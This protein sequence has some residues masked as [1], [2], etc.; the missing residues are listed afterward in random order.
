MV[1]SGDTVNVPNVAG[2]GAFGSRGT[3]FTIDGIA[4]V[5]R[6]VD[7]HADG[8]VGRW[9]GRFDQAFGIAV[10]VTL[11]VPADGPCRLGGSAGKSSFTFGVFGVDRTRVADDSKSCRAFRGGAVGM[12]AAVD[13]VGTADVAVDEEADRAVLPPVEDGT[14]GGVIIAREV[15]GDT[16]FDVTGEGA[17]DDGVTDDIKSCGDTVVASLRENRFL[18]P[19]KKVDF[20][21]VGVAVVVVGGRISFDPTSASA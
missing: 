18:I 7:D 19:P 6:S 8:G 5:V 10:G 21:V 14:V 20:L 16:A 1:T 2:V 15:T 13:G 3:K 11:T 17:F 4:V 9:A 12:V